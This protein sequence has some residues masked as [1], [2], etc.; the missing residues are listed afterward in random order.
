MGAY[1]AVARELG[2]DANH[3]DTEDSKNISVSNT[4][5]WT[6][7]A[8][9]AIRLGWQTNGYRLTDYTFD[10][11]NS[12]SAAVGG[13]Y[14][15]NSPNTYPRIQNIVLRNSSIDNS[16]FTGAA[17]SLNGGDGT[18]QTVTADQQANWGFAPNPDGSGATYSYTRTPIATVTL[19][20]V[21]FS[22]P[23]TTNT[24]TGVTNATLNN[25]HVAG[26]LVEY[27]SQFPLT[28]SGV[29]T[30]TTT[31]TDANG[32]TRNVEPGAPTNGDTWVGAWTGDQTSN[33]SSDLTLIT[34]NTG[35][36]LMGE[37]YTTG[38]GDGKLSYLQFPSAASPRHRPGRHSTSPTS[39]TAMRRSPRPTPTSCSC[40]PSATPPAPAAAPPARPPR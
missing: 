23:N 14:V 40:N 34:R 21:W 28:T 2:F 18:T 4:L 39:A 7:A 10:N 13:L 8:G 17:V 29:S 38:T 15:M 37:Q 9:N 25:L 11:F 35:D 31:Y 12:V 24:I 3:W 32:Q 36:G 22:T 30:L 6:V 16:R 1:D 27:T 26:R 19:D 5:N 33:N 20:N